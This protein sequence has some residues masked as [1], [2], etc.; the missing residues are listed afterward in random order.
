MLVRE[1]VVD[2][3]SQINNNEGGLM[4]WSSERELHA[5]VLTGVYLSYSY[6][7]NEISYPLKAVSRARVRQ[8]NV[9]GS[10]CFVG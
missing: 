8:G 7:G 1:H 3:A 6:M 5:V 2:N 9:L 10:M 4:T